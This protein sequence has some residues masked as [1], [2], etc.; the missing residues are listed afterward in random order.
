MRLTLRPALL[1]AWM[2]AL[3]AGSSAADLIVTTE[4]KNL[5]VDPPKTETSQMFLTADKLAT[6]L[7][8]GA[9]ETKMIYR[10]DKHA[11][12]S[13]DPS[14]KTYMQ[15]DKESMQAMGNQMNA[16]LEQMK[17]KLDEMPPEQ[18]AQVEKMMQQN[19]AKD[20]PKIEVKPTA[21]K[22]TID[23]KPTQK[24]EV[25]MDGKRTS[26]I[27]VAS[28]KDAGV[29]KEDAAVLSDMA[30]FFEEA[31]RANPMLARMG[32]GGMRGMN[33]IDGFPVLVRHYE[34]DKV[35]REMAFKSVEKKSV[36]A[37]TFDIPADYTARQMGGA[38]KQ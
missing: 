16:A 38:P 3:A 26:E 13:L 10:G 15:L 28:W 24:W 23:G 29:K 21:E 27:W 34:G 31:L 6:T 25:T 35:M 22:Q 19:A 32:G 4:T 9:G 12:Y 36:D 18:R 7:R 5:T 37:A 33:H 11:V 20:G 8:S 2:L 17:A 30:T 1:A 14:T